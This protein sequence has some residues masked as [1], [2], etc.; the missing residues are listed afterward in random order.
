MGTHYTGTAEEILSL[1]TYIKLLRATESTKG[2]IECHQT[3]GDLTGAQFGTLDALYH[4]GPLHQQAIGEKLLVSKSNV[5]AVIDKLERRGLVR[6]QRDEADRRRVFVHLTDNGRALF[7]EL[8]PGHV[9]AIA[10]ELSC[11]TDVEQRELGRLC[12]KLGLN[13]PE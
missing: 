11:L 5:V 10:K 3:V 6:R 9:A 8:L 1:S 13:E 4:L 12:R 2:R 7:E